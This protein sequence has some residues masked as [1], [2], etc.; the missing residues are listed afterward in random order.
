MTQFSPLRLFCSDSHAEGLKADCALAWTSIVTVK[1][2]GHATV[3]V[4][5][6]SGQ[7]EKFLITLPRL[8]I[9]GLITGSPYMEVTDTSYIQ[10]STGFLSTVSLL[11][12]RAL[13]GRQGINR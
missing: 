13:V 6:P 8:R 5:L 12:P 3:R 1:Q 2:N 7:T 9:D 11:S 4:K 10:S